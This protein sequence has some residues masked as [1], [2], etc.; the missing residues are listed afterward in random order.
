MLE[1]LA[2]AINKEKEIKDIKTAKEEENVYPFA[3]DM[4]LS[5]ENLQVSKRN[6]L[7]PNKQ[8]S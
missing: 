5:V 8:I 4:I 6:L 1:V 7:Q 3:G 2:R